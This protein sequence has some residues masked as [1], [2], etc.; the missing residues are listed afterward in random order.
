MMIKI[1]FTKKKYFFYD[2]Y[3]DTF[4]HTVV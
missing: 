4:T 1:I 2:N 3:I